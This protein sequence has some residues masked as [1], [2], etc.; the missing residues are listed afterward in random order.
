[1]EKGRERE[2]EKK[3]ILKKQ[4]ERKKKKECRY[5]LKMEKL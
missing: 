2:R 4:I 3:N 1:M 5:I